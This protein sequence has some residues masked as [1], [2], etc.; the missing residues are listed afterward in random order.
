MQIYKENI[1]TRENV[2]I[3]AHLHYIWVEKSYLCYFNN[4]KIY[5]DLWG[6][7]SPKLHP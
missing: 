2:Y 5:R 3:I 6:F 4:E 1:I 7:I